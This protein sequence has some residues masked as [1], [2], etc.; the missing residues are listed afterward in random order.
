MSLRP[1]AMSR[2]IVRS[3]AFAGSALAALWL[4]A[5]PLLHIGPRYLPPL[6]VV[7]QDGVSVWPDLLAS[8]WRTLIETVIGFVAGAAFGVGSGVCFAYLR[9][10]E[11]A[12]FPI[13]VALQTVPV[14]AFGAI[15]VI[16]FGNTITAKVVIAFYLTFFPVA[17]N[18]L[19]GLHGADPRRIEL[20]KSFGASNWQVFWKFSFPSALPTIMTGFKVGISL[21]L[22]GAIVGEWFGDTVGLGVMLLQGLYFEQVPR[23][24]MLIVVCGALG[25]ALYGVLVAVERRFFWWR[26]D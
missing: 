10:I 23:I 26:P 9:I 8:L 18:T 12:F 21:S 22:A 14:I 15:V 19:H 13:F 17:V 11:R 24:W 3:P 2:A 6:P 4:V 16:W 20:L 25:A 7:V 5:V 1:S